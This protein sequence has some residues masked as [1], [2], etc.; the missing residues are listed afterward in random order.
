MRVK[1][2][3]FLCFIIIFIFFLS[4]LGLFL[5]QI[6]GLRNCKF[7]EIL[8]GI[9]ATAIS[10]CI[11][12]GVSLFIY[13]YYN[14]INIEYEYIN[15]PKNKFILKIYVYNPSQKDIIIEQIQIYGCINEKE[16]S[17]LVPSKKY[18]EEEITFNDDIP[19]ANKKKIN[20]I[21]R[22]KG[23]KKAK[24]MVYVLRR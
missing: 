13:I 2:I 10:N 17:I 7:F 21:F 18:V 6:N 12:I 20:I 16:K 8:P 1:N 22:K 3:L 5:S 9:F 24:R 11:V 15:S 23:Y 14:Y 19:N 4:S